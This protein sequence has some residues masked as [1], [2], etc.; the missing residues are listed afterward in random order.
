MAQILR[1]PGDYLY[2]VADAVTPKLANNLGGAS[3]SVQNNCDLPGF[4]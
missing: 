4:L 2:F 3:C 1:K